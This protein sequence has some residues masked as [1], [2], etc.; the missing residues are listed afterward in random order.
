MKT[1]EERVTALERR[2]EE[3]TTGK[4]R[5]MPV[6]EDAEPECKKRCYA[7]G[8]ELSEETAQARAIWYCGCQ[9]FKTQQDAPSGE[10][11]I[12]DKCWRDFTFEGLTQDE[13]HYV[14]TL[15][16]QKYPT[17]IDEA[18]REAGKVEPF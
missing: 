4:S 18:K 1:I 14:L 13:L 5:Q 2:V 10:P 12:C 9:D 7:C 15:V 3:L 16:R 6:A 11:P 17:F 8:K